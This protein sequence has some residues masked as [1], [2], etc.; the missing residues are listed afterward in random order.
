MLDPRVGVERGDARQAR[1]RSPARG[2]PPPTRRR[3]CRGARAARRAERRVRARP[4]AAAK[5]RTSSV[6]AT[7]I[8][9]SSE[10]P[11]TALSSAT[12]PRAPPGA[13]PGRV[14]C[15]SARR[16]ES[17]ASTGSMRVASVAVS[18]ERN[19]SRRNDPQQ[20]V[21]V[22]G[23]ARERRDQDQQRD[24]QRDHAA[25]DERLDASG[26]PDR[27]DRGRRGARTRS[28]PGG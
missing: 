22:D 19:D 4:R 28:A 23:E 2:S 14:R 3:R 27:T 12:R 17:A 13:P 11:T 15:A 24:L 8:A 26:R 6:A 20:L 9:R 10:P 1:R 7:S 25:V 18:A 21:G 16:W 5:P